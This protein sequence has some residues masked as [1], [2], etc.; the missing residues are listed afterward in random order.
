MESKQRGPDSDEVAKDPGALTSHPSY[1]DKDFEGHRALTVYCTYGFQ[2]PTTYRRRGHQRKHKHHKN[3]NKKK[4]EEENTIDDSTSR[5]I[6]PGFSSFWER[7]IWMA[8][9]NHIHCSVN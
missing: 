9:M 6:R 2:M 5:H 4:E 8:H 7:M 1:T 3:G